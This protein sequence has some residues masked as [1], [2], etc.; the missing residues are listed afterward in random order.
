MVRTSTAEA[1]GYICPIC[2]DTLTRDPAG[3]G[4]VR[5]TSVRKCTFERGLRDEHPDAAIGDGTKYRPGAGGT[6][7]AS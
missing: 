2:G 4:F 1:N 6:D 3:K 7:I 5:H